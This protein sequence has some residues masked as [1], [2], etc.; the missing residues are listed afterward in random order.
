MTSQEAKNRLQAIRAIISDYNVSQE[1]ISVKL[2]VHK[3]EDTAE[4]GKEVEALAAA[5][6]YS[7]SD[8]TGDCRKRE[9]VNA[10]FYIVGYLFDKY[11]LRYDTLANIVNR[12]RTTV[13]HSLDTH[14]NL[15]QYDQKYRETYNDITQKLNVQ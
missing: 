4:Y 2:I 14:K 3:K 13:Y 6:G 8:I 11:A 9:L 10:R 1:Q 12:H 15:L 5:A 7:M